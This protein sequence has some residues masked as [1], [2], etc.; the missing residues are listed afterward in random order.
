MKK[1][2][3]IDKTFSYEGKILKVIENPDRIKPNP[4]HVLIV[5][6]RTTHVGRNE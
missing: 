2:Y 1:E 5:I 6:L 3:A 4:T